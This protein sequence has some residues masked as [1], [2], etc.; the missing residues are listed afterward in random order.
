MVFLTNL[1]VARIRHYL[2][3]N[4]SMTTQLSSFS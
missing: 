2:I 3:S 4:L 1:L